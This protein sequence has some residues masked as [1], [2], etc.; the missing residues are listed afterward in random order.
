[1]TA[2]KDLTAE[3]LREKIFTAKDIKF[4]PMKIEEWG[5]TIWIK[6]LTQQERSE[7]LEAARTGDEDE[8]KR[9]ENFQMAVLIVGIRDKDGNQVFT[10]A[11]IKKLR[12]KNASVLDRITRK[13]TELSGFGA[14]M[15]EA[16]RSRF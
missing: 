8:L 9:G 5:V 12:E 11:D 16:L 2:K 15:E 6:S 4:E 14:E 7:A 3:E 1:M 10:K 13:I